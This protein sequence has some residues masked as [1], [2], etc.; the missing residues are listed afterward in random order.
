MTPPTAPPPSGEQ[1]EIS[2]GEQRATLVEVGGGVRAYTV[3]DRDVLHPYHLNAICDGAHGTPL[4]PW[5]NRIS[6]GTY[7]FDGTSQQLA[8]TEPDKHNAIHGL[9]R[10]RNWQLVEHATDRVV[11]AA[12]LHPCPGYP[13]SLDVH[14]EYA[15]TDHGLAATT[16]ATNM[17]DFPCPYGHGQHPYLSPGTG[18]I[19]ACQLQF[20]ADTRITTDPQRQLPT[21]TEQVAGT[22]YDF[23]RPRPLGG[24]N[25]DFAFTG[26][27]TDP[28]GLAW[29]R[30][31]GAD[32]ATAALWVDQ[33]YPIIELYTADTLAPERRRSGLGTEPMTCPPNAFQSGEQVIRLEPG[34]THTTRWGAQLTS[35]EVR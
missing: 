8:L 13:F 24:L 27:A 10:W 23:S 26:L 14:V 28:D 11:L 31:T 16:T 3:G 22:A 18:L 20:T 32:G 25:I 29:V 34:Q 4:V 33:S 1:F 17:G 12:R 7:T 21:G 2:L 6:D 5:P 35:P 19:D 30:L 15:L 9:L